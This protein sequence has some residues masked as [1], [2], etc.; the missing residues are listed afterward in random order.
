MAPANPTRTAIGSLLALVGME[1]RI[2]WRTAGFRFV[3]LLSFLFGFTV[4][5]TLGRGVGLSAYEAAEAG[6]QVLGF[7]GIVWVSLA[8]VRETSLRTGILVFSKPQP[9]ERLAFAKFVGALLQ[10]YAF[11]F[12]LFLG[13]MVGRVY[14]GGGLMGAD[15]YLL[16]YLRAAGVLFFAASASFTLA[17]LFDNAIAGAL[18]GLYWVLTLAGKSFLGKFYFPAYIQNLSAF[19]AL[20]ATLLC[21]TLLLYRRSQRGDKPASLSVRL[22]LP[23][24]LLLT[25]WLFWSLIQEGNDPHLRLAPALERM[26]EQDTVVGQRAPGFLLPD[27]DGKLIGLSDYAGKILLVV[28]WSPQDSDSVL[29]LD[30]LNDLQE[31]YGPKGVQV[32]AI[33]VNEDNSAATTFAKGERLNFPMVMDWGTGSNPDKA[34]ASPLSSAYRANPKPKLIITDRRRR[35]QM[36]LSGVDSYDLFSLESIIQERLAAEPR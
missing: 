23:L 25:G 28:I 1:W 9:M 10:L 17:L 21:L 5:G 8:A 15:A 22:G 7:L 34:E 30:R 16:Q 32:V 26:G 2:G 3:V 27:Q 11:L 33:T 19:L 6:W 29:L 13:C 14:T 20:G 4:G 12:A 31:R 18:V 35:V 36:E 24:G